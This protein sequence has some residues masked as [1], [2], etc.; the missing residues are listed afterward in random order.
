MEASPLV[1]DA[2]DGGNTG[3]LDLGNGTH[4]GVEVFGGAI[5]I[6][7]GEEVRSLD[8]VL[9]SARFGEVVCVGH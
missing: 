9:S 4:G 1:V 5:V 7:I 8:G 2:G 6:D 3:E